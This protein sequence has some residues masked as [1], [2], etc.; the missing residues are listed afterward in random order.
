MYAAFLEDPS[1]WVILG[2]GLALVL[3]PWTLPAHAPVRHTI[4]VAPVTA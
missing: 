1:T 3:R 2:A 4:E